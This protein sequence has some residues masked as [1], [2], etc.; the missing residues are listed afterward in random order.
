MVVKGRFDVPEPTSDL[1]V[2]LGA[3]DALVLE[4]EDPVVAHV[5][6]DL[7]DDLIRNG[8]LEVDAGDEPTQFV[9]RKRVVG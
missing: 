9:R 1:E 6:F 3:E 5:T 4:N 2:S 8:L 7:T